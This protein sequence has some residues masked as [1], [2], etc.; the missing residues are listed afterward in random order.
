MSSLTEFLGICR[1]VALWQARAD[2]ELGAVHGIGLSDF[3]AMHYLA[4]APAGRL[5]RVDLAR[6]MALTPSGVTRLLAPL[7]RRGLV[8][9]EEVGHDARATYAALTRSGK[10]LIRDADATMSAFSE[11]ILASLGGSDRASFAKLAAL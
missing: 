6:R 4:E 7:E 8:A 1:A 9:R 11:G 2:A 3:A 5:R 10:S